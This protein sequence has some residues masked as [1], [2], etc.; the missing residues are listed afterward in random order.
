[1]TDGKKQTALGLSVVALT[2]YLMHRYSIDHEEAYKRLA[3]TKLF[4]LLN[5]LDTGL[6]LEQNKYL[7]DAC[8]KELEQGQEAMYEFINSN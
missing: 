5:D 4:E 2:K 7:C 3:S 6:Y 1:M 8:L